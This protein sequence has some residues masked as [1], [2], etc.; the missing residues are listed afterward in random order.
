MVLRISLIF[1]RKLETLLGR[2]KVLVWLSNFF[3]DEL[4]FRKMTKQNILCHLDSLRKPIPE[5]ASQRWIGSY[6]A[7]QIIFNK[8]FRW[9]YNP[10]ESDHR[11]R[12]TPMVMK[13]IKQLSR[14]EK[15]LY[16]N[17]DLW[18]NEEYYQCK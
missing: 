18:T 7:R 3:N 9:L 4:S 12:E 13:G 10:Q 16:K 5:E 11:A 14:K 2:I 8:F 15:T 1:L 6:N 17:S